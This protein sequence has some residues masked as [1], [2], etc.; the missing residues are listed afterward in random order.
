MVDL[1]AVNAHSEV[2]CHLAAL[3]RVYADTFESVAEIDELLISIKF[4][5]ELQAPC[6]CKD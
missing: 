2:F 1:V 3:N 4:T 5:A 6:P